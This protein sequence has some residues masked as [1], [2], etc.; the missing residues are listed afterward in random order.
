MICELEYLQLRFLGLSLESK[1]KSE[2]LVC[3][4]YEALYECIPVRSNGVY[5]IWYVRVQSQLP[6]VQL[7]VG[8]VVRMAGSLWC[9]ISDADGECAQFD[10]KLMCNKYNMLSFQT[11]KP[12][13]T[14]IWYWKISVIIFSADNFW[15]FIRCRP[16]RPSNRPTAKIILHAQDAAK[17][18]YIAYLTSQSVFQFQFLQSSLRCSIFGR[19]V[20]P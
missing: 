18:I 8:C 15:S 17:I 2:N 4:I 19:P 12:R 9:S 20:V 16:T 14:Q 5:C 3:S 11:G 1:P 6:A 13:F 10:W 7:N